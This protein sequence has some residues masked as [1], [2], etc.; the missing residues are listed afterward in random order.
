ML[1]GA[2]LGF[3]LFIIDEWRGCFIILT[4]F[5]LLDRREVHTVFFWPFGAFFQYWRLAQVLLR[6]RHSLKLTSETV[7]FDGIVFFL[8]NCILVLSFGSHGPTT[9]MT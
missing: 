6:N 2:A 1:K 7:N 5:G 3:S 9:K 4:Y 8:T